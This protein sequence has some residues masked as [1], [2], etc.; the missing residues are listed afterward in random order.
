LIF[1]SRIKR[2][3]NKRMLKRPLA[4]TQPACQVKIINIYSHGHYGISDNLSDQRDYY[5]GF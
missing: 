5:L 4:L 2:V 1:S 3:N